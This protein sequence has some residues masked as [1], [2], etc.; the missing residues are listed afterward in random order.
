MTD[1]PNPNENTEK[2]SELNNAPL[3]SEPSSGPPP[4][5]SSA[6]KG[7]ELAQRGKEEFTKGAKEVMGGLSAAKDAVQARIKLNTLKPQ[8]VAAYRSLGDTAEQAGWNSELCESVRKQREEVVTTT[9][10]LNKAASEAE[11]AKNTPGAGTAKQALSEAKKRSALAAGVLDGLR[12][13]MGRTLLED[14]S[15]PA[16]LGTEQRAEIGRLKEEIAECERIIAHGKKSLLTKPML[17]ASVLVLLVVCLLC[18]ALPNSGGKLLDKEIYT[19]GKATPKEMKILQKRAKR[20]NVEAQDILG[21][22]YISGAGVPKDKEEAARWHRKAAEQG[23]AG[24]Q[25]LLSSAYL[26]GI[27]VP[28]DKAEAEK[29]HRKSAEQGDASAQRLLGS[30]YSLGMFGSADDVEAVKWFRKASDQGDSEAIYMLGLAYYDGAGVPQNDT[31]GEKWVRKAAEQGYAGA[32]FKLGLAYIFGKGVPK[33]ETE[34]VN[35]VRKAARQGH[36]D[37]QKLLRE[38]GIS[39]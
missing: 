8:L 36:E 34:A 14:T 10:L 6:A 24:S 23:H 7:K 3:A 33:N 29:W 18:F 32:Q 11:F 30:F 28:E 21:V 2:P 4:A 39:W 19:S 31:E 1:Q 12:E 27:G 22:C 26:F 17:V 38:E 25:F 37:A 13:K 35:W 5:S 9:A 15:A 16:G 20:G